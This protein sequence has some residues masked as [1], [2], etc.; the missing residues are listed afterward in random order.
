MSLG[1]VH[2]L[3]A[4]VGRLGRLERGPYF[5]GAVI[6]TIMMKSRRVLLLGSAGSGLVDGLQRMIRGTCCLNKHGRWT[7]EGCLSQPNKPLANVRLHLVDIVLYS[8]TVIGSGTVL[9]Y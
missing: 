4:S 6:I 5:F 8:S 2:W 7:Y 9:H 3:T 1:R